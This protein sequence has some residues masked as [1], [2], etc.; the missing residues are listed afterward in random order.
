MCKKKKKTKKVADEGEEEDEGRVSEFWDIGVQLTT[1]S[2]LRT[3]HTFK[4]LLQQFFFFFKERE[5]AASH[6]WTW[7]SHQQMQPNRT[8]QQSIITSISQNVYTIY[9]VWT[10]RRGVYTGREERGNV[11]N[12]SSGCSKRSQREWIKRMTTAEAQTAVEAAAA[13]K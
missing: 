3:N 8:K 7:H 1:Q 6:F 11:R 2:H 5:Q 9:T 12:S 10:Q 4:S 13:E